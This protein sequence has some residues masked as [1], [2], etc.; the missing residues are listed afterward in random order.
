MLVGLGL[1]LGFGPLVRAETFL[2]VEQ[3]QGLLF[4]G[5]KLQ[6]VPVRLTDDQRKAI[7]RASRI[8]I[9]DQSLARIHLPE[10]EGGIACVGQRIDVSIAHKNKINYRRVEPLKKESRC[11]ASRIEESE[12]LLRADDPLPRAVNRRKRS[13]SRIWRDGGT[14]CT[15]SAG[16]IAVAEICFISAASRRRTDCHQCF[17]GRNRKR[18]EG[19]CRWRC[20]GHWNE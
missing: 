1:T 19:I 18:D 17:G 4:P 20:G 9:S 14:H 5:E 13:K 15:A 11:Y 3:A 12:T 7:A 2:T 6:S 10:F 8:Q 16:A